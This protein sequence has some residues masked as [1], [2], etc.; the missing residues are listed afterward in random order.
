MSLKD[1]Q[2]QQRIKKASD[3]TSLGHEDKSAQSVSSLSS[4]VENLKNEMYRLAE[5]LVNA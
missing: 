3:V 2:E 4:H 5:G 1:V